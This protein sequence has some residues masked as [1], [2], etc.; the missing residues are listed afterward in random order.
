MDFPTK[1]SHARL[2]V[3]LLNIFENLYHYSEKRIYKILKIDYESLFR[4]SIHKIL[5]RGFWFSVE[6]PTDASDYGWNE[7]CSR[8]ILQSRIKYRYSID[9]SSDA[10][11]LVLNTAEKVEEFVKIYAYQD[12]EDSYQQI[13]EIVLRRKKS[14]ESKFHPKYHEFYL[15]NQRNE[16]DPIKIDWIKVYHDFQGIIMAPYQW[17]LRYAWMWYFNLDVASG[18]VWD[19]STIQSFKRVEKKGRM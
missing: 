14:M 18:C 17:Q 15:L 2:P 16:L 11:I 4:A 8:D 19:V 12:Q 10:K 6:F 1:S 7:F 13:Q 3:S 5:P 9:I